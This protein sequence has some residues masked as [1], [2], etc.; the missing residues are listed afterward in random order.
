MAFTDS[1]SV[2]YEELTGITAAAR[3]AD[4]KGGDEKELPSWL[5][6]IGDF[7]RSAVKSIIKIGEIIVEGIKATVQFVLNG[8][9]MVF[10]TVLSAVQDVLKFVEMI[11]KPLMVGFKKLFRWLASLFGWNYVLYT[12]KAIAGMTEIMMDYLPEKA[13]ETGQFLCD[14]IDLAGQR[15]DGWI[16]EIIKKVAPDKGLMSYAEESVTP[17][18][19][20]YSYDLSNDPLQAKLEQS[21]SSGEMEAALS[22]MQVLASGGISLFYE[23]LKRFEESVSVGDE[24]KEATGFFSEAFKDTKNFF[25][26]MAAGILSAVKGLVHIV[27]GGC[28]EIVSDAFELMGE[29]IAELKKAIT[30][31]ISIP[32]ISEIYSWL[33]DDNDKMTL[34]N[35]ASLLTALPATIIGTAASGNAPFACEEEVDVFLDE[36]RGFLGR[37]QTAKAASLPGTASAADGGD[38]L[39]ARSQRIMK[40]VMTAGA[41]GNGTLNAALDATVVASKNGSEAEG[42]SALNMIGI[43]SLVYEFIWFAAS[44]PWLYEAAS[45]SEDEHIYNYVAW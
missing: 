20:S 33:T 1:G 40:I 19:D 32:I 9:N 17:E 41:F 3:I 38:N 29:L 31:E 37:K 4:L 21:V 16:D 13:A 15:V 34:L 28:K 30:E 42:D 18:D 10:E 11:F 8:V 45:A 12:K 5:G 26:F 2:I 14:R 27:L 35:M 22:Q 39:S 6:K 44:L 43:I 7:F 24:F 36:L 23:K 25:S